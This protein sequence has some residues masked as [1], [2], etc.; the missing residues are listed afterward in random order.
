MT[1]SVQ[2]VALA[3][4]ISCGS[5][6]KSDVHE[7]GAPAC[8]G[9]SPNYGPT[10]HF[11]ML[12]QGTPE[13][14]ARCPRGCGQSAYSSPWPDLPIDVSLPYGACAPG[15]PDCETLGEVPCSSQ[16]GGPTHDFRCSCEKGTWNCRIRSLGASS[17][18]AGVVTD[19]MW[20][21]DSSP[22]PDTAV[23][24]PDTRL[25]PD[26]APPLVPAPCP[27][28][29]PS[30]GAACSQ[31]D[32]CFYE[33]CANAGRSR[34]T[35]VDGAWDVQTASCGGNPCHSDSGSFDRNCEPGQICVKRSGA[36]VM[37][38]CYNNPCVGKD[39]DLMT[40]LKGLYDCSINIWLE[41]GAT[42]TC[43]D[44]TCGSGGK[45]CQ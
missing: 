18:D 24:L 26:I 19:G 44:T 33:D 34:A 36:I 37:P 42:I 17:C 14:A 29:V 43:T 23:A 27:A 2:I 13:A 11:D 15:T 22:L 3:Q 38:T 12:P 21:S 39:G 8:R 6:G 30:H 4:A 45:T 7:A 5:K 9:P 25:Q 41:I 16:G 10:S 35:C 28:K 1:V 31:S 40:C 32:D 20:S